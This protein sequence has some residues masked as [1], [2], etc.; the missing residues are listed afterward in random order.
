MRWASD[1]EQIEL[2]NNKSINCFGNLGV[3]A[4]SIGPIAVAGIM[5]GSRTAVSE[6]TKDI[7]IETAFWWP[8]AIR[9]R[10]QKLE[11]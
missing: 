1:T 11:P 4:D 7:L 6:D 5:G 2:L 9:G 8:D 3:I 10:A